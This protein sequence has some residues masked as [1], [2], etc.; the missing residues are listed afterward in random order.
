M[1]ANKIE[2]PEREEIEALSTAEAQ[3]ES[4]KRK[5]TPQQGADDAL[6]FILN[7]GGGDWREEEE[8][9][10]TRKIDFVV[11]PLVQRP[12]PC[13]SEDTTTD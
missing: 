2:I 11:V 10:V 1:M 5:S 9:S 12:S 8:R 7:A 4:A 6:N 13:L 3:L